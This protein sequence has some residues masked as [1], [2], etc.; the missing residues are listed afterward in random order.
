[1]EKKNLRIGIVFVVLG[2]IFLFLCLMNGDKLGSLFAGLAGG[3]GFGGISA[4][5]RYFYWNKH[6][7]EYKEKLEIENINLH[8]ERNVMYRDKAGRYAYIVCMIIIPI[9]AFVFSVLNALDIYNSLV[10]IRYLFVLWIVLYV[11]GVIYYRKLKR[12]G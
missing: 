6:K 4:I 3:F 10:I 9:S 2:V 5:Y 7:E 1:M 12:N 11:V 8:D